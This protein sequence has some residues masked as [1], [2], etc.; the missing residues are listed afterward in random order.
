MKRQATS[1]IFRAQGLLNCNRAQSWQPI[2]L[3]YPSTSWSSSIS[4]L[5]RALDQKAKSSNPWHLHYTIP[6]RPQS[7]WKV[8]CRSTTI[9]IPIFLLREMWPIL[10]MWRWHTRRDYMLLSSPKI[11]KVCSKVRSR[12]LSTLLQ[13]PRWS[14]CLSA[15]MAALHIY[16]CLEVLDSARPHLANFRN[17]F[18]EF[19]HKTTQS[20]G[21]FRY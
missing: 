10:G 21:S 20:K 5:Q 19:H 7:G 4:W 11:S 1:T 6:K 17:D 8:P 12:M 13:Q 18:R 16:Q 15:R 14:A 9:A 2:S 3:Y